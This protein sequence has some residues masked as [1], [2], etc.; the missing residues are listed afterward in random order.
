MDRSVYP[1]IRKGSLALDSK[2]LASHMIKLLE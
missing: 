2:A 1:V